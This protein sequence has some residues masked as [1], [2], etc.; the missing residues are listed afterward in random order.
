[1]A[2]TKINIRVDEKTK[3]EAKK[4]LESLGLDISSG[5]KL[6]LNSVI[7]TQSI[8]FEIKTKNGYTQTEETIILK[9]SQKA[10][11]DF[12]SAKSK[13]YK[14]AKELTKALL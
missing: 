6:F 12:K 7:N 1:M 4:T 14:S 2:E 9:E 3:K 10:L 13:G 5:V 11:K 8:P